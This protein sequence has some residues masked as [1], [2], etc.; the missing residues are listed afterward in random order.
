[1]SHR[2]LSHG[3]LLVVGYALLADPCQLSLL[4]FVLTAQEAYAIKAKECL[5]HRKILSLLP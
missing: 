5:P 3:G 1:M 4:T 2:P